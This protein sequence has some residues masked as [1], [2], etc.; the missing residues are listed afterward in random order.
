M[1]DASLQPAMARLLRRPAR[2]LARTGCTADAISLAGFVCA[3]AAA[4]LIA[5]G[6]PL[7]GLAALA[8]NRGLDGLDGAVAR[9]SG[10]TDR[11][12]FLDITLDFIFYAAVPFAFAC[13]DPPANALP[14]AGLL[15]A[16]MGTASSFLAFAVLAERRRMSSTDFPHKGLYY[17]G[18]LTEGGETIACFVAMCLFPAWFPVLAW[19]FAALCGVTACVRLWWG[20][21]SFGDR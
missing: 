17:L 19:G 15:F 4:L 12:A 21:Q 6:M 11:G 2:L 9:L 16:F 3:A 7:A 13:A 18:G 14:A 10:S 1:F 5:V 20:F 8:A